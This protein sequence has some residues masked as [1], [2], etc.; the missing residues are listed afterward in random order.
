MS[1]LPSLDL[2]LL[3]YNQYVM[4]DGRSIHVVLRDAYEL[5]SD[6]SRC[7]THGVAGDRN[8]NIVGPADPEAI[9]WSLDGA[10]S[11]YCNSMGWMP[12]WLIRYLDEFARVYC[13]GVGMD[14][15]KDYNALSYF[16][17]YGHH[18][19]WLDFLLQASA[20]LKARG[21]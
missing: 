8:K 20:D 13:A 2:S 4:L 9:V 16:A 3:Q 19:Q 10:I 17:D 11:K 1:T 6:T 14:I 18:D 15:S 5:L 21:V 7:C 12:P